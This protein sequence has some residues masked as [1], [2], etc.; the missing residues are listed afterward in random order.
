MEFSWAWIMSLGFAA[1]WVLIRF[2]LARLSSFGLSVKSAA[3]ESRW[4]PRKPPLGGMAFLLAFVAGQLMGWMNHDVGLQAY[5][6]LAGG[7]L[8]FAVGLW[9]DLRRLRP[10]VKLSGQLA[11]ASLAVMAGLGG[12]SEW[13][14]ADGILCVLLITGMMNS[15]NMLDNMDGTAALAALGLSL[16]CCAGAG[17]VDA[18]L[19]TAA[20]CAFLVFNR[21]PA[22][23]YM[24]DSGSLLLGYALAILLLQRTEFS[25]APVCGLY[26]DVLIL[27][28]TLFAVPLSDS[29]VVT[30]NRLV[31][32]ISPMRGGRDHTTHHFVYAGVPENGVTWIYLALIAVEM[33]VAS[34]AW[35]LRP[36]SPGAEWPGL[37]IW[38]SGGFFLALFGFQLS[39][40]WINLRKG[41]FRYTS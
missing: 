14:V 13:P 4:N 18:W 23:V 20:L 35:S 19:I 24:G 9:D 25:A 21:H 17:A 36:A 8:A 10:L 7:V 31:H 26:P 28:F 34:A 27:L 15:I 3:S 1:T 2:L 33:G 32:G 37:A 39:L 29:L 30:I 40:S 22:S 41:R 5:L 11:A 16:W 6:V 12:I 38:F